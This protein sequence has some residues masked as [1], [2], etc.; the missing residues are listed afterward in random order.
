MTPPLPA[1]AVIR[2]GKNSMDASRFDDLARSL[3]ASP[4]RRRIVRGLVGTALAQVTL[5]GSSAENGSAKKRKNKIKKNKF[6]CVDVGGKCFGKDA[7]CCSGIC[8]GSGKRSKC[9]AHNQGTCTRDDNSC[10]EFVECGIDGECF[11]TTGKAGFC[12]QA[13]VC[14]CHPCTKDKDCQDYPAYG[15]GSACI[16]CITNGEGSCIDVND[17]KKGT[18]CVP[19]AELV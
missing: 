14:D 8:N 13:G 12:G 17:S 1:D 19:P 11:R 18:A 10:L 4:S 5:L 3:T 7:K 9:A 2:E 16:V 6:G 15:P